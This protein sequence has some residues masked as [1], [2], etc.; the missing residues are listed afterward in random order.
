MITH[1][2][3]TLWRLHDRGLLREGYAA[4]ITVFDPDT[5]APDMPRVVTDLP[6]KP[7]GSSRRRRATR[8]RSSMG[9]CSMMDGQPT[10]ARP[11][12]L[13]REAIDRIP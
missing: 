9:G 10:E 5:V 8:P 7:A 6:G 2:P 13:L 3:A 1:R 12:Q 4:D 11:G